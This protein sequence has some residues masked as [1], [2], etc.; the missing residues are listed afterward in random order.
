M[1]INNLICLE[2]KYGCRLFFPPVFGEMNCCFCMEPILDDHARLR[3]FMI[4]LNDGSFSYKF[5]NHKGARYLVLDKNK[6]KRRRDD[7]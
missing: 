1:N 4:D 2:R 6:K 5:L 7:S 3:K